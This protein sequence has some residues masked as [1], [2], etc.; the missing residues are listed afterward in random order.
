MMLTAPLSCHLIIRTLPVTTEETVDEHQ[1]KQTEP[2]NKIFILACS[3]SMF[4]QLK[5]W[6]LTSCIQPSAA[7]LEPV[8]SETGREGSE[9]VTSPAV[10]LHA[11]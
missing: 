6:K 9:Q 8:P 4:C 2:G 7:Y 10:N 11:T 3:F 5:I 1:E